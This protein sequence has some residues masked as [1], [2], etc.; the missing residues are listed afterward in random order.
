M[1]KKVLCFILLNSSCFALF[2]GNPVS[3]YGDI[4]QIALPL[5]AG[6]DQLSSQNSREI[7]RAVVSYI[8]MELL[9]KGMKYCINRAR[10]GKEPKLNPTHLQ[11]LGNSFPSGHTTAAWLGATQLYLHS[12]WRI[13]YSVIV[14]ASFV[15]ASR[16]ISNVHYLSD[17]LAGAFIGSSIALINEYL[18]FQKSIW[19]NR[20]AII[21]ITPVSLSVSY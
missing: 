21:E 5:V 7:N 6:I 15:G 19:V 16:V 2:N 20:S 10:P 18:F 17:V 3:T 4:F 8:E 13:G 9:V 11:R 12:D 14:M 1:M